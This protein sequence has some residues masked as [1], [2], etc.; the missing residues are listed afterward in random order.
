VIVEIF[1]RDPVPE[2]KPNEILQ[3][4]EQFVRRSRP[5]SHRID[6][7]AALSCSTLAASR[8]VE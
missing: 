2:Q 4:A 3:H 7:V 8:I 1:S 5:V 6:F